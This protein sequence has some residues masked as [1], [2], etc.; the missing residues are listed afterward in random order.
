MVLVRMERG[1]GG[2]RWFAL[3]R[4]WG[5]V[6]TM[7]AESTV[8]LSRDCE[9]VEI[10]SGA[11][12]VLPVGTKV[13]VTQSLGGSW[14]VA[15]LGRLFRISAQNADA[16]GVQGGERPGSVAA[17]SEVGEVGF[18]G[19]AWEVLRGCYDPEIP[20]NIVD[21]GLVYDLRT[22]ELAAGGRKVWVKM[23]LT[24]PGCGMGRVIAGDA[25]ERLLG[26]P[27]VNEAEVEIVWDPPWHPSMISEA[28]RRALGMEP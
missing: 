2:S 11:A 22:E 4:G 3:S 14:T 12:Q 23:T 6:G 28:G 26:L 20:V 21:L 24:A 17:V 27:G 13:Q 9:A 7:T 1:W 18:E 16:L 15:A 25:R 10:P 19:Q 8:V 5:R